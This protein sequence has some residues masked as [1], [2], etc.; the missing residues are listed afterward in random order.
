MLID[1]TTQDFSVHEAILREH[2]PFFRSA[3]DT[4]W[5]EGRSRIIEMP[6][7]E[8]DV[9]RAF[10]EWLYFQQIASKPLLPPALPIDDG[11]YN[12]L[13]R[14]YG[15]GEKVQA[16]DF[17]DDVLTAMTLKS[18][19]VAEDGT[20]T[21]PSHSAVMTLYNGTSVASPARQFAVDM[22]V[23]FGM[24]QWIPQATELN[25]PEF[26]TDLVHAF[27]T[28]NKAVTTHKQ[29]NFPRRHKWHKGEHSREFFTPAPPSERIR[30]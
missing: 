22:Y 11:E 29:S 8:V 23:D 17:C 20:R 10:V 2:S 1:Q 3:L 24:D 5:R 16:D 25:H 26:M 19:D 13:A 12:F 6:Q 30:R 4:K 9:V 21:F 7:D 14:M 27:L 15:F 28:R 18:D